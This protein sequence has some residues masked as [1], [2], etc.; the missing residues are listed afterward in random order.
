M[1]D[2]AFVYLIVAL[3]VVLQV[4][5][6]RRLK[7]PSGAKRNYQLTAVAIPVLIMLATRLAIAAGMIHARVAEQSG[8]ER[9][10]TMTASVALLAGPLLVTLAALVS[11]MRRR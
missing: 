8:V 4:M 7:L 10:F 2:E 11:R 6:I 5:L 3:N 9:L 1:P